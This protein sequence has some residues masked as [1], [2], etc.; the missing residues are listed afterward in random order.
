MPEVSQELVPAAPDCFCGIV[1][2]QVH[3]LIYSTAKPHHHKRLRKQNESK[4]PQKGQEQ[5]GTSSFYKTHV[6]LHLHRTHESQC[7]GKM[8][9][10][11]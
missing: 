10:R 8:A 3:S 6:D 9:K 5:M 11:K 7:K 2:S 1:F 4:W